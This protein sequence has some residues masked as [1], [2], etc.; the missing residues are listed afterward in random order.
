MRGPPPKQARRLAS[1]ESATSLRGNVKTN[2]PADSKDGRF[3]RSHFPGKA[4]IAGA[5]SRVAPACPLGSSWPSG[6]GTR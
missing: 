2:I 5:L 4:R 6:D 3:R 1:N